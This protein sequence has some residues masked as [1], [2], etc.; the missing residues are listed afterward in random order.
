MTAG[1][2]VA[3]L[4]STAE[5]VLGAPAFGPGDRVALEF[6]GPPTVAYAAAARELVADPA[7]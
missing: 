3:A 4:A 2:D 1:C 5:H 6:V 7:G